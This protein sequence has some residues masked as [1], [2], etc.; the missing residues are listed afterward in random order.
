MKS[1][2]SIS[3]NLIEEK[4]YIVD[5][6]G[7]RIG[8]V[9]SKVAE[10]L[11]GKMDRM[12]RDY[13]EPMTHVVVINAAKVDYTPKRGMTKFY[14]SYSGFA[15]GLKFRSL[16]E[17][18]IAHADR[19]IEIAVRGML[20]KTKQADKMMANLKIYTGTEHNHEAQKPVVLD[21]KKLKI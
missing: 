20:P 3:Q 18:M 12:V 9:A 7:K 8:L 15:G 21:L 2:S 16:D 19:P 11:Q 13:H 14:K 10:V 17:M 5:A 4:W 1:I 6:E